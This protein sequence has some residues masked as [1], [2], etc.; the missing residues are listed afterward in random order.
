M[1]IG[2]E[3]LDKRL[4]QSEQNFKKAFFKISDSEDYL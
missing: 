4:I 2:K 1:N 3:E